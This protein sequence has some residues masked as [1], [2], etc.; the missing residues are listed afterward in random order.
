MRATSLVSA[1]DDHL[2]LHAHLISC[3]FIFRFH[4]MR[5]CLEGCMELVQHLHCFWWVGKLVTHWHEYCKY[6]KYILVTD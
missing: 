3:I 5:L 4:R 2:I 1:T 6:Y